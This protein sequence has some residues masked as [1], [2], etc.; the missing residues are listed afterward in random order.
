[1]AQAAFLD[2][3]ASAS[4]DSPDLRELLFLWGPRPERAALDWLEHRAKSAATAQEMAAWLSILATK[5]GASRVVKLVDKANGWQ[6]ALRD[7]LILALQKSGPA[8]RLGAEISTALQ[9]EQN[10]DRLVSYA[11]AAE[12]ARLVDVAK[13]AWAR[14]LDLAPEHPEALRRAAALAAA[15]GNPARTADLLGRLLA[16]AEGDFD[17]YYQYAD[18]L[19]SLGRKSEARPYLETALAKLRA[20]P[21][22]GAQDHLIEARILGLLGRSPETPLRTGQKA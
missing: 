21:T 22:P 2:L 18:A 8:P 3:A 20:R 13:K 9:L 16:V 7:V 14:V 19:V 1:M 4:P 12:A 11:Q 10:P 5:G 15:Q 17:V 6:D